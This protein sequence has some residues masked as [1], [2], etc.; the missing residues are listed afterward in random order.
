MP[1]AAGYASDRDGTLKVGVPLSPEIIK[2]VDS[3]GVPAGMPSRAAALRA[4]VSKGLEAVRQGGDRT[5]GEA[6]RA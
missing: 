2:E 4:L 6:S 1:R 5:A 3:W